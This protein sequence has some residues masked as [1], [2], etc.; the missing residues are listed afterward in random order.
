MRSSEIKVYL[1]A[2]DAEGD[3]DRRE[4]LAILLDGSSPT[5]SGYDSADVLLEL[6]PKLADIGQLPYRELEKLDGIGFEGARLLKASFAVSR[7]LIAENSTDELPRLYTTDDIAKHLRPMFLNSTNEMCYVVLL[8]ERHRLLHC[9]R[10][11]LGNEKTTPLNIKHIVKLTGRYNA[12]RVVLAH[13]H[14]VNCFPSD[15]DVK[16]TCKLN[17]LLHELE[18]KLVDHLIFCEN[19]YMSMRREG[20]I[21]D[22]TLDDIINQPI[23]GGIIS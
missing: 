23:T 12:S 15:S 19:N 3:L 8:N 20:Y 18:Y 11:S 16:V 13:N 4:A 5:H 22:L 14:M 9:E 17:M 2:L 1:K 6:F 21:K 7:H 10:V